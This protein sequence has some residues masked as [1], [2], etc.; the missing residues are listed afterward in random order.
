MRPIAI[1]FLLAGSWAS[2]ALAQTQAIPAAQLRKIKEATVF[3]KVTYGP[4]GGSGSGFV[5]HDGKDFGLIVTNE[6]VVVPGDRVR[7][8]LPPG[9]KGVVEVVFNS[10]LPGE[11]S[12]RAE[13][14]HVNKDD[15]LALLKVKAVKPIPAP[16]SLTGADKLPETTPV[17]VCGFPFG[18]DLAEGN[19]NPEIS[20]GPASVSSNRL[21][22]NGQLA[23]VQLN[24]ALNPGN[25]G[26]PVVTQDGKL[27]GVAVRTVT[28]AGIGFAVPPEKVRRAVNDVHFSAPTA[29]W[30]P[31]APKRMRLESR[32]V[33]VSGQLKKVNAHVAPAPN[34]W[35]APGSHDLEKDPQTKTYAPDLTAADARVATE[36]PVPE[37]SHFWFWYSWTD[38]GGAA[39][40]SEPVR[41][42]SSEATAVEPAPPR[43]RPGEAPAR[44]PFPTQ[45]NGIGLR[46][47]EGRLIPY[48]SLAKQLGDPPPGQIDLDE[49]NR[50]AAK[51]IGERVTVDVLCVGAGRGYGDGPSLNVYNAAGILPVGLDFV[52]DSALETRLPGTVLHSRRIAIRVTGSVQPPAVPKPWHLFV[53]DEV[54]LLGADGGLAATFARE[55]RHVHAPKK[56]T[57]GGASRVVPPPYPHGS[58][59]AQAL[60]MEDFR[61]QKPELIGKKHRLSVK[62]FGR[63]SGV[64]NV[65][66]LD[67][68][69][70][71]FHCKTPNDELLNALNLYVSAEVIDEAWKGLQRCPDA[72]LPCIVEF[73]AVQLVEP[74]G[75]R[76][77]RIDCLV[78][79][80]EYFT[81]DDLKTPVRILETSEDKLKL[82]GIGTGGLPPR[83]APAPTPEPA[84]PVDRAATE[85]RPTPPNQIDLDVL[86]VSA[87][88]R[89]GESHTVE[90]LSTG[91]TEGIGNGPS[92]NA[93]N[94][95][96]VVPVA[97]DF[98]LDRSLADLYSLANFRGRKVAV[99]VSGTIQ[100]PRPPATVHLF[101]VETIGIL[102]P[103]GSA[104]ATHAR[105]VKHDAVPR[106]VNTAP[107]VFGAPD[108][109]FPH[110]SHESQRRILD[111][112]GRF[113]PSSLGKRIR[114]A[115]RIVAP[116][117]MNYG[118]LPVHRLTYSENTPQS[119]LLNMLRVYA[120]RPVGER[121]LAA[122]NQTSV[123]RGLPCTLE[124]QIDQFHGATGRPFAYDCRLLSVSYTDPGDFKNRVEIVDDWKGFDQPNAGFVRPA[125]AAD[126]EG[127]HSP[128][129]IAATAV[130]G[131]LVLG[132]V[133]FAIRRM[134][135][136]ASRTSTTKRRSENA[137]DD[138]RPRRRR[139]RDD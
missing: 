44:P 122:V 75:S 113:D 41:L 2:A 66:G 131:L 93:F 127:G 62:L 126:A 132:G 97:L 10:G 23:T 80:V 130:V 52:V 107:R 31:G 1:A 49:L 19:K 87:G 12:A 121:L 30:L 14:L 106:T 22:E 57:A 25:S 8:R 55:T 88:S 60:A 128:W 24:G 83:A 13:I 99:R 58:A 92:L 89:A 104:F 59:E 4:L 117:T 72:K 136:G 7:D 45:D 33:D 109:P 40:R 100:L 123:G 108:E 17:Y 96:G 16:I 32:F 26:G 79:A 116:I 103:D 70:A 29:Q 61:A 67:L 43:G 73:Q 42:A 34:A 5:V 9:T 125:A 84:L 54:A 11:W 105:M 81:T 91:A 20:I 112:L 102:R 119:E 114:I 56:S 90:I 69:F 139:R 27:V 135:A 133:L 36:F 77:P 115:T 46:T 101:V 94:R 138:E 86:N 18:E 82:L 120:K 21:D 129:L 39:R 98:V 50:T 38:R 85:L 63:S 3:V 64:M 137:F 74:N 124:I 78:T 37:S 6:H 71:T 65:K 68:T 53:V 48:A 118:K 111:D 76:T 51:R 110:G 47:A 35:R 134:N 15:D 95:H 28:G